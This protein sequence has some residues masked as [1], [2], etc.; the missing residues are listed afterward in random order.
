MGFKNI[1]SSQ[2]ESLQTQKQIH[3]N[4][5]GWRIEERKKLE[6]CW[7]ITNMYLYS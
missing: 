6:Q 3:R 4:D 2:R 5:P 7:K 1:I